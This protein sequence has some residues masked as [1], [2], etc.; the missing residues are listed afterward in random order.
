MD[1]SDIE[2][3]LAESD[4]FEASDVGHKPSAAKVDN[5]CTFA[6]SEFHALTGVDYDDTDGDHDILLFYLV[7]RQWQRWTRSKAGGA[8]SLGSSG[9][10]ISFS[11]TNADINRL[12]ENIN[13]E[14]SGGY[15]FGM[16]DQEI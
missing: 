4:Y 9:Q 7:M 3:F 8:S 10:T 15:I 11:V 14:D 16:V 13:E 12:V 1:H 5:W 6:E 2:G